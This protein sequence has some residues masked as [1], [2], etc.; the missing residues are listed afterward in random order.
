MERDFLQISEVQVGDNS[1]TFLVDAVEKSE[2]HETQST[3]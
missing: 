3:V 2:S 1:R